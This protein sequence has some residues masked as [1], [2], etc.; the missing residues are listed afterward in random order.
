MR[1]SLLFHLQMCKTKESLRHCE[2]YVLPT[3]TARA[4]Q[5]GGIL[6]NMKTWNL[7][8]DK[9][10]EHIQERASSPRAVRH[11]MTAGVYPALK[12]LVHLVIHQQLKAQIVFHFASAFQA[13]NH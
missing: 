8:S 10:Y 7:P 6:M 5:I 13:N 2:P 9:L 12:V 11:M 3:G 1:L 4:A